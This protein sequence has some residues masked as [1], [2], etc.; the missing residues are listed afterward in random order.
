MVVTTLGFLIVVAT[1]V[2]FLL[3]LS[4][5]TGWAIVT[6][7]TLLAIAGLAASV[8]K[9]GGHYRSGGFDPRERTVPANPEPELAQYSADPVMLMRADETFP[10]GPEDPFASPD[11][12][13][14]EENQVVATEVTV[15]P[16]VAEQ[17]T[18]PVAVATTAVEEAP[19]SS[20]GDSSTVQ[21]FGP[22]G[23]SVEEIV[24]LDESPVVVQS[25]PVDDAAALPDL[26][27]PGAPEVFETE[28]DYMPAPAAAEQVEPW[29]PVER[30]WQP[31]E[32]GSPA[33][34]PVL[35]GFE[36]PLIDPDDDLPAWGAPPVV[37]R[38]A[39][40]PVRPSVPPAG[41][42]VFESSL[43]ADLVPESALGEE[44]AGPFQS[45]LLNELT[46]N[47][48][49]AEQDGNDVLIAE[50]PAVDANRGARSE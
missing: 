32:H 33:Q 13:S 35:S 24:D 26:R 14:A 47:R 5:G 18:A 9:I 15:E 21:T 17:V 11:L 41:P 40:V 44:L 2:G 30:A 50:T 12:V 23:D 22:D 20:A 16:D 25:G 49:T 46:A 48:D 10:P 37:E 45:R 27:G 19:L 43:L 8:I 1:V 28:S 4:S 38:V 7:M 29:Q 39:P 36:L 34:V 6:V 42:R 3:N 31:D